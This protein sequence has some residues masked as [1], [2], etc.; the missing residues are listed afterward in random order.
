MNGVV[1]PSSVDTVNGRFQ[2]QFDVARECEWVAISGV[3]H[4]SESL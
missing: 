3:S 1:D 4:V 2:L